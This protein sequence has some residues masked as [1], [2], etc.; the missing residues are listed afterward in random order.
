MPKRR[1][2]KTPHRFFRKGSH[3]GTKT[4]PVGSTRDEELARAD[5]LR[6]SPLVM[7]QRRLAQSIMDR[8]DTADMTLAEVAIAVVKALGRPASPKEIHALIL[9]G[10]PDAQYDTVNRALQRAIL[11]PETGIKRKDAMYSFV[12]GGKST[13]EPEGLVA[14]EE[15]AT[16]GGKRYIKNDLMEYL[17]K[18]PGQTVYAKDAAADLGA[19]ENQIRAAIPNIRQA[20][21]D[22]FPITTEIPAR[23]WMYRPKG[24]EEKPKGDTLFKLIGGPTKDG[25]FILERDDGTLYQA[26]EM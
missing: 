17:S 23:A 26:K 5:A 7:P 13:V 9:V 16:G 10:R 22:D 4:L 6:P 18:R 21:G 12:D 11:R 8:I 19:S 14:K 2:R 3:P 25:S 24:T 15:A 1:N 20:H